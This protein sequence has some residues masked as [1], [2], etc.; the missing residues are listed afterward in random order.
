LS[1]KDKSVGIDIEIPVDKIAAIMY[2]FLTAKEHEIF[3]L[4]PGAVD[5]SSANTYQTPTILWSAKESVFKWY[6]NGGVDFRRQIQL[7]KQKPLKR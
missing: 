5:K 2:K 3:N 7:L 6:A 1:S 4:V